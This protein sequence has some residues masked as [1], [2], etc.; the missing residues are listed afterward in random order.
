MKSFFQILV[1]C[2]FVMAQCNFLFSQKIDQD[3][4]NGK[5]YYVYPFQ[6]AVSI[7]SNYYLTTKKAK[8]KKY[9]YKQYYIDMFGEDYDKHEYRKTKRKILKSNLRNRKNKKNKKHLNGKFKKAVRSNPYPL[10]EQ[11][12]SLDHDIVPSLNKIP[13]GNYVQYFKGYYPMDKKGRVKYSGN[14]V[15][16]YFSIK[17]NMLEGDAV[18]LNVKGDTV[19]KGKFEKGLKVGEWFLEGR[20][21]AHSI[22][23]KDARLYIE[24]GYPEMDTTREYVNYVNGSRNGAYSYFL[25]SKNPIMEGFYTDN[26]PSGNWKE[27]AVSFK[28]KGKNKKRIRDNS[29]ITFQYTPS[30]ADLIVR[31]AFIR[32]N[33][34]S[35]SSFDSEYD[36]DSKYPLNISFSRMYEIYRP[37]DLDIELEEEAMNSYEGEEYEDE[38]YD[39]EYYDDEYYDEGNNANSSHRNMIYDSKMD[40]YISKAKLMDSL[41]IVFKFDGLYEKRYTNGQLMIRYEFENGKL[42]M[43]DTIFWDNGKPYDVITL[44]TDSYQYIQK[45]YDYNGKLYNELVFDSIGQFVRVNFEPKKVKYVWIDGFLAED[46]KFGKYYFYDKLDTLQFELKDSLVLF[47]SWNKLDSSLLYSRSYSPDENVLQ[48]QMYSIT[49]NPS[50]NAEIKFSDSYESWTGFKDYKLGDLTMRTTTSASYNEYAFK[51][52]I[53]QRNVNEFNQRFDLTDDYVLKKGDLPFTGE[54]TLITNEKDFSISTGKSIKIELP[55]SLAMSEKLEKDL[56]KF[57]KT[58]KTDH[59]ILFN[60]IDAAEINEDF[61]SGIFSSFMG[62]FLGEYVQFP[63]SNEY[64]YDM[65]DSK[66]NEKKD[67]PF[68]KNISGYLLDGKPQGTWIIRDQFGELLYEIPFEKGMVNGI[69]KEYDYAYPKKYNEYSE[70]NYLKDSVPKKKKHY[71][72]ATSEYKNGFANG[73]FYQYNWL[74]AIKKQ[75][76][77]K[78]GFRNG[79]SF[80][81]NNV[82][83]TSL[84]YKDG[85]LDGYVRTFLTL[86]GQDSIL[87]FDLNFKNGLLQG[88]SRSYHTNGNLAKKGFFLNGDAIDDYEAF[89][90]LGFKYHY[91]K[92]LYSFPVE[93]KIWEENELS[94]RYL[95]DWRDSIYFQPTDITS[96]QSL[97]R[98]LSKLGIGQDY[99]ER[100]YYGRPSLVNKTRVDY[101][102]TKYYPNDTIARDGGISSGKKVGCWKYYSYEGEFLYEVDYFDTILQVNDSIQ[103]KAKG[104]LTDYN[105]SGDK[106]SESY[107]IEKF[108]KYDCSHTDHYEIRQLKTIWQGADSMDRMNGYAKN[109]YDNGVLQNEG[110]MKDGLPSGVWKF[111]DPYGKLNQVGVYILGKR[112]G[113]WLGGDLSKTKY[114]GDICLN[115][116]LPNL[117]EEIKYREKLLDIV[118]TNY[119]MG[120]ALNKEF[121][122][123]NMNNFN[124]DE[125]EFYEEE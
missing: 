61:S 29:V 11:R 10:L 13:D 66:Y 49:G 115:P 87:L 9:T 98:T 34:I 111:Y 109:Y 75:S 28:G 77:Y 21:V 38:Y 118:I 72:Y 85:A 110:Q 117:E 20:K 30:T 57:R 124:E 125:E 3:T 121:Y 25:N 94:V 95:F 67:M 96:T 104:I 106:I 101:H 56:Y 63:Y 51:D 40:K 71:L 32:K 112:D 16:G 100:P 82:A 55:R 6:N 31:Q 48:F 84:N 92:F 42:K 90:T 33:L 120:K 105:S 93:E 8:G 26:V 43:E 83:Y 89:D 122:D 47:R 45:V 19:K 102:I 70:N 78:D 113:R 24:R 65:S 35:E 88:E 37:K 15:S 58:G 107:I 73:P 74:G 64:D 50:L 99:Y 27:R 52:S 116:N 60:T 23:K 103:F 17:D 12:Y 41:G 97:D 91:V 2:C 44:D 46:S 86:K 1:A 59:E 119:K 14:Q 18:W 39:E 68:S 69:I 36:F 22:G 62:G 76:M 80:E 79:P 114:L 123:V 7:H 53:P 5:I 54:F 81:R 4:I 108:E